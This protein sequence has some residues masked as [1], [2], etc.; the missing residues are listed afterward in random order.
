MQGKSTIMNKFVQVIAVNGQTVAAIA[1][2]ILFSNK[3]VPKVLAKN[4]QL[5]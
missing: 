4:A 3:V 1:I 5:A 2:A